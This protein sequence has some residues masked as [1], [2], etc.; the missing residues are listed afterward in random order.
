MVAVG[1]ADD[2]KAYRVVIAGRKLAADGFGL[3]VE[4][5]VS[6]I[7]VPLRVGMIPILHPGEINSAK[8]LSLTCSILISLLIHTL[9]RK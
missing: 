3:P 8:I 7:T 2:D 6:T 5:G 9:D 4:Q 1:V